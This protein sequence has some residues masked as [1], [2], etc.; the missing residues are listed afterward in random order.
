MNRATNNWYLCQVSQ[1]RDPFRTFLNK[2]SSN[3]IKFKN[4]SR[5]LDSFKLSKHFTVKI[6]L[7][8]IEIEST[9]IYGHDFTLAVSAVHY[10]TFRVP[11]ILTYLLDLFVLSANISTDMN[12]CFLGGTNPT[13]LFYILDIWFIS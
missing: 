1:K 2:K 6:H 9:N 10:C 7:N 11:S 13:T 12:S 4:K 8:T 5:T 3:I